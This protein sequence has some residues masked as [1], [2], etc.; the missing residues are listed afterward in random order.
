[1]A[2]TH[3]VVNGVEVPLTPEEIAALEA[4]WVKNTPLPEAESIE[5]QKQLQCAAFWASPVGQA[6]LAELNELRT[7]LQL[8]LRVPPTVPPINR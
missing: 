5:Q 1:M 2:A 4:E 7:T 8:P 6:V 3:R